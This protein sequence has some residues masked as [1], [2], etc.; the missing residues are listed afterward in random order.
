M[1]KYYQKSI[2]YIVGSASDDE[3]KHLPDKPINLHQG[4]TFH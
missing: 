1:I 3:K 4:K 2:S